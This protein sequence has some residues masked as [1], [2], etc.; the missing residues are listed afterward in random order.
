[1]S[2]SCFSISKR[3]FFALAGSLSRK[4][5]NAA[6]IPPSVSRLKSCNGFSDTLRF[7]ATSAYTFLK[8]ST[9]SDIASVLSSCSLSFTNSLCASPITFT[10]SL[11]QSFVSL[12][13]L[14][15]LSPTPPVNQYQ[16]SLYA[17]T[18]FLVFSRFS[19]YSLVIYIGA[20]AFILS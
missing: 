5:L 20:L 11:H 7:L 2:D 16:T 1:M 6:S 14:L 18:I 12:R 3:A 15:F 8:R 13:V 10:S 17:S 4:Y 9:A 19:L